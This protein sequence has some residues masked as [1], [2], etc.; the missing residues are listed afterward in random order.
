MKCGKCGSANLVITKKEQTLMSDYYT[1][2]QWEVTIF[3][4]EC[5]DCGNEFEEEM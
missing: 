4:I 1:D 5:K 3:H 2:E